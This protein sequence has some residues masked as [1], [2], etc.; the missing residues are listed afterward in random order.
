[1]NGLG[2]RIYQEKSTVDKKQR[3]R[4]YHV[5][6]WRLEDHD[7]E[8]KEIRRYHKKGDS[9]SNKNSDSDSSHKQSVSQYFP[10]PADNLL[11]LIHYNVFRGL[12]SN[13]ILLEHL[14]VYVIPG[15]E[16]KELLPSDYTFPGYSVIFPSSPNLPGCLIP[17]QSQNA[18]SHS[19]WID[20][21][22][23]P[24]MRDNLIKHA[25]RFDH[26]EFAEDLIGDRFVEQV[27]H[28]PR[29]SSNTSTVTS[30]IAISPVD[31]DEVTTSRKG[32][33]VWGE[34]YMPSNWEATPGFLHKWGWVIEGCEDLV[35]SSNYWR[36]F[37]GE[38]P[39]QLN[40]WY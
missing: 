14:A 17:T 2:A 22:P 19:T 13:K 12:Y 24:K 31:D 3:H 9:D 27:F 16:P 21:L 30:D 28:F 40:K 5:D 10:L 11:H 15:K 25:T 18:I 38:E 6:R 34:P 8:P 39:V 23:F 37:R 35:D 1:M 4:P 32:L 7:Y 36:M 29:C 26:L 33:I 20:L